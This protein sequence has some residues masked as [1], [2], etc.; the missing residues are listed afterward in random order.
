MVIS[1]QV[2][3]KSNN[4]QLEINL[5]LLNVN[6]FQNVEEI[7]EGWYI[8][9]KKKYESETNEKTAVQKMLDTGKFLLIPHKDIG[10]TSTFGT[11]VLL[12]DGKI[13]AVENIEVGM[14]L[15]GPDGNLRTVI[16]TGTYIS[17]LSLI[18]GVLLYVIIFIY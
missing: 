8:S 5:K 17:K 7:D 16:S 6:N 12:A 2:E 4:E 18:K 13:I 3:K 10:K 9:K 11:K 1:S 14:Q 15:L